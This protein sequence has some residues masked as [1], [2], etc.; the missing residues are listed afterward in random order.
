MKIRLDVE[1]MRLT[2]T[3]DEGAAARDF[4]SLLPLILTLE[5][6]AS[7]EKIAYLPRKLTTTG[8]PSGTAASAG[9]VMYYA[10][11]GNLALFYRSAGEAK[12]LVKLGT[13]DAGLDLLRRPGKLS[14]EIDKS[15]D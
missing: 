3:L 14:V 1:G 9:D 10:P 15:G 7:T 2:A 6:Y 12:G 11:W 13:L 5:D 8:E 4:A